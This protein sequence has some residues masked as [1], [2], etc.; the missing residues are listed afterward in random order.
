MYVDIT[1]RDSM[2]YYRTW[3]LRDNPGVEHRIS[4]RV[5]NPASSLL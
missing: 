2:L 1:Q 5:S 3:H 4:Y